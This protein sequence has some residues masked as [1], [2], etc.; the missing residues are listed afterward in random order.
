MPPIAILIFI[1]VVYFEFQ[2]YFKEPDSIVFFVFMF[3][4]CLTNTAVY[5]VSGIK[6]YSGYQDDWKDFRV[7]WKAKLKQP[8]QQILIGI[9]NIFMVIGVIALAFNVFPAFELLD[10]N[11]IWLLIFKL[12]MVA[13][14]IFML[15]FS[16][17]QLFKNIRAVISLRNTM[18]L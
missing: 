9:S 1:L 13:C 18:S 14:I 7:A 2:T 4:S 15:I 12:I 17:F 3:L 10:L 6:F 8:D 11:G 5:S 16:G